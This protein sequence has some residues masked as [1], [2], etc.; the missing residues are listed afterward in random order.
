MS[1]VEYCHWFVDKWV[2]WAV[3]SH[4]SWPFAF[5]AFAVASSFVDKPWLAIVLDSFASSFVACP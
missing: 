3:P 4:A 2:A 5:V 1:V